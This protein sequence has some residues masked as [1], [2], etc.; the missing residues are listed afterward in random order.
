MKVKLK[1]KIKSGGTTLDN[2]IPKLNDKVISNSFKNKMSE[3]I[4]KVEI[5]SSD[6][7]DYRQN[8]MISEVMGKKDHKTITES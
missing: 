7:V 4:R 8:T 3:Q 6:S 1:Y 2:D 5:N